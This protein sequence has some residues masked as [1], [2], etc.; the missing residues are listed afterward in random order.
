VSTGPRLA[1]IREDIPLDEASV[2]HAAAREAAL[3][4]FGREYE[5]ASP[6]PGGRA[7]TA[8]EQPEHVMATWADGELV[9]IAGA[10][11]MSGRTCGRLVAP[12]ELLE[13]LVDDPTTSAVWCDEDDGEGLALTAYAITVDGVPLLLV[14]ARSAHAAGETGGVTDVVYDGERLTDG[15]WAAEALDAYLLAHDGDAVVLP[16]SVLDEIADGLHDPDDR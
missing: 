15:R 13:L 9:V 4:A 7:L 12:R 3:E 5:H 1:G 16:P 2:Y 10:W 8:H 11:P 14:A 6:T